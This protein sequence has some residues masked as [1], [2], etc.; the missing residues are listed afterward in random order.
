LSYLEKEAAKLSEITEIPK[1]EILAEF[2]NKV[3]EG[4]S[5]QAATMVWK[6]SHKRQL[7]AGESKMFVG[8]VIGKGE[9][10]EGTYGKYTYDGLLVYNDGI[11]ETKPMSFS[12]GSLPK[13]DLMLMNGVYELKAF[14]KNGN[15]TRI[16]AVKEVEESKV[17]KVEELV[18]TDFQF[19]PLSDILK[20][21]GASHL[22]HGWIGR[23]IEE[24]GGGRTVGFE[25]G[26]ED[27]VMPVTCWIHSEADV[28]ELNQ[29]DEVFVYGYVNVDNDGRPTV[30]G[31]GIFKA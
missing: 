23:I 1:D 4:F 19:K 16:R 2:E 15:L 11:I 21:A 22:L 31:S 9:L 5:E 13:R 28:A 8:R 12:E 18:G 29:G 27:T 20:F 30:N 25:F 3:K 24:R 26:D 7:G 14:E 17:P 6:S 10:R